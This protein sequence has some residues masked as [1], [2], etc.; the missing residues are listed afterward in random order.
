MLKNGGS[1]MWF[2]MLGKYWT[3]VLGDELYERA[4]RE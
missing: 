2:E 3:V 4:W 1:D